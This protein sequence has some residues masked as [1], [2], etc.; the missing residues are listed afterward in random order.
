MFCTFIYLNNVNCT[1]S[2]TFGWSIFKK[3]IKLVAT[4]CYILRQNAPGSIFA[5]TLSHSAPSWGD[6]SGP[7]HSP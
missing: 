1:T 5:G 3:I 6:H 7:K 2:T 4:R